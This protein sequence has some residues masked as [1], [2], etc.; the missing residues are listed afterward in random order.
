V[1]AFSY[2]PLEQRRQSHGD[3]CRRQTDMAANHTKRFN[4]ELDNSTCRYLCLQR[5][6]PRRRQPAGFPEG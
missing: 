5:E 1:K 2:R 6:E 3:S 4:L